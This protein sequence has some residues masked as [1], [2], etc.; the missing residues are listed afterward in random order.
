MTLSL[1]DFFQAV[2]TFSAINLLNLFW[3]KQWKLMVM[4]LVVLMEDL[5]VL[6][7]PDDHRA[8]SVVCLLCSWLFMEPEEG[9]LVLRVRAF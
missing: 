8:S 4:S 6:Q 3:E 5:S 9:P 2:C 7:G 1:S